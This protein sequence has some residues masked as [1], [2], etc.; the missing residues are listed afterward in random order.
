MGEVV[1]CTGFRIF[2]SCR[3]VVLDVLGMA[4][5]E[6]EQEEEG[7]EAHCELAFGQ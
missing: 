3:G 4:Y 1:R 2:G 7:E 5:R 6:G